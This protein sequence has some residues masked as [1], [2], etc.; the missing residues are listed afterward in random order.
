MIEFNEHILDNGLTLITHEDRSTPLAVVN[1]LYKVGSRDEHHDR[2]GF[3]HLFEH[4]MFGGSKHVPDYDKS[5]Q[6][7]G[8]ENNAFTNTDITNYYVILGAEN[9]ETALWAEADR[10]HYLNLDQKNLDNQKRVVIEEFKQR[11]LNVPYG[12]VWLKLRPLAYKVHPYK[13]P[14]IGMDI[15]HI[16]KATLENVQNFHESYYAPNNAV[17]TISGNIKDARALE[18][19]EKWF[20]GIPCNTGNK[21]KNQAEPQQISARVLETQKNVPLNAIYKAF[22]MPGR[23]NP[24]YLTADLLSDL[25][26]RGKSSRLHETLIKKKNVFNSINAYILGTADPGLLV[27]SGKVNPGIDLNDADKYIQEEVENL[28]ASLKDE[29]VNKVINQAESSALFSET[30]LLNRSI[31]LSV[32]NSLG[33]TKLVND[34]I[35]MIRKI[36][37]SDILDSASKILVDT[38]CSTLN[39]LA[40]E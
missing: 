17:I 35:A 39:Y 18:L 26:G 14:T 6:Q 5:L 33:N 19:V 34:E 28:K 15:S 38:N 4:L 27:I 12:D 21:R 13:W 16:E 29:E 22:H 20:G 40:K 25:L 32:A 7:V 37:K 11:Y 31:N 10:M 24:T 3:A 2:T 8:A 1:L 30:E 9:I 23:G 36:D